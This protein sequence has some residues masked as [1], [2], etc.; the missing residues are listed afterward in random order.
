MSELFKNERSYQRIANAISKQIEDD[1]YQAEQALPSERDLAKLLNVSR[2]SVR[3]AVIALEVC[4]VLEVKNG[5]G[6][7]VT[8]DAKQR[9]Q[10]PAV[11][12]NWQPEPEFS[13]FLDKQEELSPFS[14]LQARLLIEPEIASLAAKNMT[15]EN[16]QKIKEAYAMSVMDNAV[17]S[18][19]YI[20]DRLMHI[21]IAIA[22]GNDAY[23]LIIRELLGHQ[24]GR[25]FSTLQKNYT[26]QDMPMRS[27]FEHLSIVS[28]LEERN[29]TA[30]KTAMKKH[31]QNVISIFQRAMK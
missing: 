12:F 5:S 24:F 22:S 7:Y 14:L 29:P 31:L 13:Q 28:A 21:R 30:A 11:E 26:P 25:L 23:E 15:D 8:S 9:L 4:G 16:M 6:I 19:K 3:E 1:T 18:T 2:A 17:G 20:G 10:R 27:Q